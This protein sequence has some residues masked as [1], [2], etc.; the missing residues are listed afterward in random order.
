MT[1]PTLTL[2]GTRLRC[3][4]AVIGEV[5]GAA[6]F[7]HLASPAGWWAFDGLE[8]FRARVAA[9]PD[10]AMSEV[11]VAFD[12]ARQFAGLA[13]SAIRRKG[14]EEAKLDLARVDE[15]L[16]AARAWRALSGVEP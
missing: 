12:D 15:A 10:Q 7:Q 9:H 11:E 14:H 16:A 5:K 8:A 2:D 3:D 6:G 1:A 13:A 4:G